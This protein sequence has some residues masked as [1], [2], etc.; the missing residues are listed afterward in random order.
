MAIKNE[1]GMAM[2]LAL[3]IMLVI[4]MLGAALWKYSMADL[5]HVSIEEKKMQAHYYA[6]SGAEIIASRIVLNNDEIKLLNDDGENIFIPSEAN[7]LVSDNIFFD[8][9]A[10]DIKV[11]VFRK[12][13]NVVIF[14]T[15]TVDS[16]SETLM[17][18]LTIVNDK[19]DSAFW[20]RVQ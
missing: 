15:G 9:E 1:S 7:K 16:I 8:E 10:I 12:N 6:R 20:E 18:K 5:K 4:T 19:I 17:L 3:I 2:P 14:S 11:E 13:N